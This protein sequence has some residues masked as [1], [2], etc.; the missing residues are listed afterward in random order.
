V[1]F[2]TTK[3]VDGMICSFVMQTAANTEVRGLIPFV[4]ALAAPGAPGEWHTREGQGD[5]VQN[6]IH[7]KRVTWWDRDIPGAEAP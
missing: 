2:Q 7:Q 6:I 1:L 3:V 5:Q 4:L